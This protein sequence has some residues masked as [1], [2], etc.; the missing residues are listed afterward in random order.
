MPGN[1]WQLRSFCQLSIEEAA[2]LRRVPRPLSFLLSRDQRKQSS[3]EQL[4][5]L[6]RYVFPGGTVCLPS[7]SRCTTELLDASDAWLCPDA[8]ESPMLAL[9]KPQ[10]VISSMDSQ[11]KSL[12]PLLQHSPYPEMQHIGRLDKG[13]TGLLLLSDNGDLHRIVLAPGGIKKTYVVT[14]A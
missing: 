9:W 6:Q 12:R 14:E 1:A 5:A 7:G 11:P 13:T 2:E 4:S 10:N 3:P 8:S